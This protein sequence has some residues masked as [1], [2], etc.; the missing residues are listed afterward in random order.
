MLVPRTSDNQAVKADFGRW[1]G[2][3]KGN[4]MQVL[5]GNSGSLLSAEG[6]YLYPRRLC[7][8]IDCQ[9]AVRSCVALAK[10]SQEI[11]ATIQGAGKI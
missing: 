2:S 5:A 6:N 11:A 8:S 4:F 9:A 3:F 10:L 1:A 7:L